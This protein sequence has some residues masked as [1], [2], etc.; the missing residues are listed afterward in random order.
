MNPVGGL[1]SILSNFDEKCIPL[2]TPNFYCL[3]LK[4]WANL[5]RC[6]TKDA[7]HI[8]PEIMYLLVS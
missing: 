8:E 2:K 1:T 4:Q 6:Q 7:Q 3:C 5:V